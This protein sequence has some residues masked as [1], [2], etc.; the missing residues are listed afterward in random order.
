MEEKS[1]A[2]Y[3]DFENIHASLYNGKYGNASYGKSENRFT[4]QEPL[5]KVNSI[6]DYAASFGNI[7]INKAY[8]NW[9]W[10]GRYRD[11]LLTN[12]VELIQMFPPGPSAKNGADIKMSLDAVEDVL[13]FRHVHYVV[14]VGG[15]SDYI[16][17]AQKAKAA[18]R[19]VIGIGC[20]GATNK[21][22]AKSCNE[23]VYYESLI[24]EDE[25]DAA[26]PEDITPDQMIRQAISQ[27]A[28]KYGTPWVLK[29]GI[30]PLVKRLH[31][32]F[33]EKAYDADSFSELLARYSD[34]FATRAGEYDH[35][36]SIIKHGKD[37]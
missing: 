36:V 21:Y 9:Q 32:T 15:D 27:L 12:S 4:V 2:I 10:F 22:W 35:E 25:V 6:F 13:R 1:V 14:I 29:A 5:V 18:G 7:V 26:S 16:A 3:W 8:C 20:E 24:D 34:K 19:V 28:K 31:P 23:F 17:L 30:R 11:S 33:D 37:T